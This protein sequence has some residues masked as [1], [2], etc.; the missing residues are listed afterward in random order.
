[1]KALWE[2]EKMLVTN[3][4]SFSHNVLYTIQNKLFH[5]SHSVYRLQKNL[6][7]RGP[8]CRRLVMSDF[9]V[10]NAVYNRFSY[11]AAACAPIHA[12]LELF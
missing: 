1:M 8:K 2:Q 11:I 7:S 5:E 12:F 4:F 6:N 10:F 9:M 3:I